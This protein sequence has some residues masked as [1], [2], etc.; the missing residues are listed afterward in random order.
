[1]KIRSSYFPDLFTFPDFADGSL[2]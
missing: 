2:W 1:M